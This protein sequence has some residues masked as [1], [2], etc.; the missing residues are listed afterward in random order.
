MDPHDMPRNRMLGQCYQSEVLVDNPSQ[1]KLPSPSLTK[2]DLKP[3]PHRN[4]RPNTTYNLPRNMKIVG[5]WGVLWVLTE[6]HID[7]AVT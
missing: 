4:L 6:L 7:A 1:C 2:L 5:L 3:Q